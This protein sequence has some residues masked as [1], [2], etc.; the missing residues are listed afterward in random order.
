MK[1]LKNN[2]IRSSKLSKAKFREVIKPFSVDLTATQIVKLSGINRN[3]INRILRLLRE[4]IAEISEEQRPFFN[5]IEVDE[6]YFGA[7]RVKGVASGRGQDSTLSSADF[8]RL[9]YA[10]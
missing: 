3:S 6:R 5:V 2:Y 7:R 4:R 10:I 1:S 8:N 9:T